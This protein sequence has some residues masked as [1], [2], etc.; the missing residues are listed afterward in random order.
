MLAAAAL[1]RP[2]PSSPSLLSDRVPSGHP[3][4]H[5]ESALRDRGVRRTR[6]EAG[7]PR[8]LRAHV[9]ALRPVDLAADVR[10]CQPKR[11]RRCSPSSTGFIVFVAIGVAG[12]IGCLLGGWASDRFGRSRAAV[13]ALVTSGA[14]CMA[15]P[16]F[17]AAPTVVLVVF[18]LVWGAAVIADS[19]V[20][21]TS[22]SRD[23][24]RAVRRHRSNRADRHRFPVDR[25]HH[26]I[27]PHRRRPNRLAV[28]FL[29]LA[30]GPLIGAV[31][32]SALGARQHHPR[33]EEENHGQQLL[34]AHHPVRRSDGAAFTHR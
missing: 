33:P 13:A 23:D 25:R 26:P 34:S 28:S 2:Q 1:P 12:T 4:D 7:Q 30:P 3:R 5:T 18:L 32:M 19:G 8:L 14:C 10:R 22:L 11:S 15:S 20:F 9:G 29:L 27:R 17:F 16:I 31:A 6:T 24:R 21:S